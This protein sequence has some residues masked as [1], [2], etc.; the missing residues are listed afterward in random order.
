MIYKSLFSIAILHNYFS[1]STAFVPEV[2]QYLTL[3]PSP[4][5]LKLIKQYR[6]KLH[7][8]PGRLYLSSPIRENSSTFLP[9][10]PLKFTFYLTIRDAVFYHFTDDQ[11]WQSVPFPH[12]FAEGLNTSLSIG[13]YQVTAHNQFFI[14]QERAVETAFFIQGKPLTS[15][16]TIEGLNPVPTPVYDATLKKITFDT[17]HSGYQ[18][19]QAFQ[20]VYPV[21]PQWPSTTLGIVEIT[22]D[23]SNLSLEKAYSLSFAKK[24]QHWNYYVVA[25]STLTATNL[26]ITHGIADP[27]WAFGS[28]IEK[29]DGD[30]YQRLKNMFPEAKI[31]NITSINP[32]PYQKQA[33]VGLKLQ[34]DGETIINN[35]PNPAPENQGVGILNIYS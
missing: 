13:S 3:S 16:F 4:D 31:F 8:K 28:T 2:D 24:T 11:A 23:G 1:D 17:T 10:V 35:L 15:S 12:F 25:P 5:C 26:S 14:P 18:D 34:Q 9:Q 29:S 21:A 7:Y 6:L 27:Q 19:G 32:L 30:I 33:K 20:V 22:V